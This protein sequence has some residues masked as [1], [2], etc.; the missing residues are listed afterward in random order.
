LAFLLAFWQHLYRERGGL[1]LFLLDEPQE[2]FDHFNVRRIANTLPAVAQESGARIIVTTSSHAFGRLL[3]TAAKRLGADH[4]RHLRIHP[5]RAHRPCVALG[6]FVEAVEEKRRAFEEAENEHQPA[7]DY[8][9]DLRIYLEN[10]LHDLFDT[11]EPGLPK[12]PT[13]SDLFGA[14]RAR[15]NLGRGAFASAAFVSLV[16]DPDL[17]AGCAFLSLLNQSHHSGESAISYA[18][19]SGVAEACLRVRKL[20]EGAHEEYE[21]WLRRD[22]TEAPG[23]MPAPP[24]AVEVRPRDLQVFAD[25]AAFTNGTGPHEAEVEENRFSTATFGCHAVYSVFSHNFGFAAPRLSRAIVELS[26]APVMDNRL[27]I[28]LH[29][30]KVYARRLL[31][32]A[33]MPGIVV[34]ASEAENPS[35]RPQTLF[36]PTSEV[37]L[38]KVVGILFDDLQHPRRARGEAV[39][40]PNAAE[41]DK[42]E[43]VFRVRGDS[44][45]PLALPGQ[46]VLGGRCILPNEMAAHEGALVA[47]STSA[48][49]VFK[50]I[51]AAVPHCGHV[52]QFESIGGKGESMLARTEDVDG[53]PL[54]SV[55]IVHSARLIVGVAYE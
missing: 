55:P 15:V 38:M 16:H 1:A 24:A 6:S 52:R 14:V 10:R 39:L 35:Q 9:K 41:L 5:L 49:A 3:V 43:M 42:V 53:D 12:Q 30:D 40:V 18:E 17:A 50:R 13:L 54:S 36:L 37:R 11:A 34:L 33:S 25:L 48:G 8:V 47:V 31:R 44:A 23:V 4:F 27:V 19:V 26:G 7:R 51:G 22:A 32:Q 46:I 2:L 45:L 29:G 20:L 28:A 21:L